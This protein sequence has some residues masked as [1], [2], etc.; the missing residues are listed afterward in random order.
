MPEGDDG[1]DSADGHRVP[2]LHLRCGQPGG[3]VPDGQSC[4]GE[5]GQ[6]VRG[7]PQLCQ[8]LR[9]NAGQREHSHVAWERALPMAEWLFSGHLGGLSY[10]AG[11]SCACMCVCV[12]Q[13]AG[14][15]T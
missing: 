14:T 4:P 7:R 2:L 9:G 15:R 12:L 6:P 1:G 3:G 5:G 11:P 8:T 13:G 10:E